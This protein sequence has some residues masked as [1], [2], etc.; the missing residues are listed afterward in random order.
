MSRINSTARRVPRLT[1]LPA[2]TAGST[3][4]R[5]ES[6]ITTV[7]RVNA[8]F[9]GTL[10]EAFAVCVIW[11]GSP[12]KTSAAI[13]ALWRLLTDSSGSMH[14][15]MAPHLGHVSNFHRTKRVV[16]EPMKP[17]AF[18]NPAD[19]SKASVL[20]GHPDR[21]RLELP[22][23]TGCRPLAKHTAHPVKES[24]IMKRDTKFK[25]CPHLPPGCS[26]RA[27]GKRP[28]GVR[29]RTGADLTQNVPLGR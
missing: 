14:L 7:Y 15:G 9:R 6:G 22:V 16:V 17:L 12:P 3:T 26:R 4:M 23:H 8:R 2:R 11:L 20:Y 27:G 25:P 18:E 1:G 21:T 28:W 13:A 5:S 29:E 24:S 10:R 19:S